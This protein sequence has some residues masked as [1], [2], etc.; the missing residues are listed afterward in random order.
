M[1]HI[2]AQPA[3]AP[4]RWPHIDVNFVIVKFV[5]RAIESTHVTVL[6]PALQELLEPILRH[7]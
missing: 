5:I 6:V 7:V 3:G 4:A 1:Y 2:L